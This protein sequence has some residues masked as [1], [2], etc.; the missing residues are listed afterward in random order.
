MIVTKI[1]DL[2]K[3]CIINDSDMQEVL[4]AHPKQI[5]GDYIS[6]SVWRINYSYTTARGNNKEAIKYLFREECAW[7]CIEYVFDRYIEKQNE[8]YPERKLSN[9]K[10]LDTNFLGELEIELE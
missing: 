10:I 3:E 7:D 5:I 4:N 1:I 8:K 9:V 2:L 6:I